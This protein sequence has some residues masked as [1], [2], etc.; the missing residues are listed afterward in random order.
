MV[1]LLIPQQIQAQIA[2]GFL[3]AIRVHCGGFK[4]SGAA[5]EQLD[6]HDLRSFFPRTVPS[7]TGSTGTLVGHHVGL[8][9]GHQI[10]PGAARLVPLVQALQDGNG[11]KVPV[12]QQQRLAEGAGG[13]I[14]LIDHLDH[15]GFLAFELFAPSEKSL[16][17]ILK[18]HKQGQIKPFF[19]CAHQNADG[20]EQV[21]ED[22][23]SLGRVL[24]F[25]VAS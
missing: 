10:H 25:L 6:Q 4:R 21:T 1:V 9:L 22:I 13:R 7:C 8:G 15:M 2:Y 19:R 14:A 5:L 11:E 20:T 23:L 18:I 3:L 24:G 16:H 12:E 17:H